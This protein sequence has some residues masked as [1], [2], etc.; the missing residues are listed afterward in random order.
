MSE[1]AIARNEQKLLTLDMVCDMTGYAPAEVAL[2]SRTV[3]VGAPLQELAVFLHAC[4]SLKLDPLLRQAYWIRR[5]DPPKGTLQVGIDGFRKIADSSGAYAGSD[6]PYFRG[7]VE[8]ANPKDTK[9]PIRAPEQASVTIWKMVQGHKS[10]FTGEARWAEWYPG[11]GAD[12]SMWRKMPHHMLA[13][14]A[15][16]QALRKGFPALLGAV[17]MADDDDGGGATAPEQRV[18]VTEQPPRHQY[19]AE[20]WDRTF[21]KADFGEQTPK[22]PNQGTEKTESTESTQ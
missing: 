16:G 11:A 12:G 6:P 8:V 5:G 14:A 21:G 17:S 19:T 10:A 22:E 2:I 1:R 13:K 3:A 4:R 18:Q 15:E 20:E 7:L 9:Q